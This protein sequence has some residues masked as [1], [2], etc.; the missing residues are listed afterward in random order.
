MSGRGSQR[1]TRVVGLDLGGTSVKGGAISPDGEI[2]VEDSIPTRLEEGSASLLE[3]LAAF[4]RK[5][6]AEPE[7]T[8]VPVGLGC[9]GLIERNTGTIVES[10]N[11]PQIQGIALARELAERLGIEALALENDAN[12]AALGEQWL[13]AA[14]GERDVLVLTLG[15]GIGGGLIT[16]G[17]LFVGASGRAGEIGHVCV[18]PTAPP[19]SSGVP[20]C[21]EG[22]ASATAATRRARDQKLPSDDPGNLKRLTELARAAPGPE[23]ELLVEIGR[24]LGRG[25]AP[26]VVLLDIEIFVIGGGFSAAL[27]CMEPGIRAGLRERAFGERHIRIE[28][29]RLGPSAGWI[30]AARLALDA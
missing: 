21:L 25:L 15:T 3:R 17:K 8:G 12:V 30:G 24:D 13:G 14:K 19:C 6:G 23:R 7:V 10:P 20:G 29:A 1:P 16:D 4:A 18:D 5:L 9:P 28:Q 2:L 11:L 26:A 22:F 27:D